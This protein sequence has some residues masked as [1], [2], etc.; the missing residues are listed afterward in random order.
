MELLKTLIWIVNIFSATSI[1]VLVLMQH[2]KG[3]EM[4][5]SL[6]SAASG[7]LFGAAGPGSFLSKTTAAV[8]VVFFATSLSLVFLF[9]GDESGLGVMEK[10]VKRLSPQSHSGVSSAKI[11]GA[12][13][14]IP[15]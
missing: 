15:D 12:T 7:S 5:A 1:I 14:K 3:A 2:G 4:G 11:L 10:E 9:R 6:G 13:A 8:A